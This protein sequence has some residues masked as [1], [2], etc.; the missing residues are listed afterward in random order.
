MRSLELDVSEQ[1][2]MTYNYADAQSCLNDISGGPPSTSVGIDKNSC[3]SKK[4]NDIPAQIPLSKEFP[5]NPPFKN[6]FQWEELCMVAEYAGKVAH[7]FNN[8][9]QVLL[10]GIQFVMED[11]QSAFSYESNLILNKVVEKLKAE[12]DRVRHILDFSGG[13]GKCVTRKV[14]PVNLSSLIEEV[15][16]SLEN[17]FE[18]SGYEA[19]R[20][21]AIKT[22]LCK[23]CTVNARAENIREIMTCLLTNARESMPDGG[24]T[25]VSS[26]II[27]ESV[28]V[29][30]S[31]EGC[32]IDPN[33][34][35]KIFEPYWTT[36]KGRE[37]G[38]GLS[39]VFG[40]VRS[41]G[42][43]VFAD[44]QLG[45]GARVSFELPLSSTNN[46]GLPTT[47]KF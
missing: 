22:H 43:R 28:I 7:D 6:S 20:Q 46:K 24:Q 9:I 4:D 39:T 23:N 2:C 12:G 45:Q 8:T 3:A 31:D 32:G 37:R 29:E 10:S 21:L 36:K 11:D 14:P 42:G 16:E 30:V 18:K 44:S 13:R 34:L 1:K 19:N 40:L 15:V 5:E 35:T 38:A 41:M 25:T 27:N 33:N 47:Q 17:G 26:K